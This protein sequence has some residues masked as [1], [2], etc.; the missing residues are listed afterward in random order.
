MKFLREHSCKWVSYTV[1][2]LSRN[3]PGHAKLDGV[4]TSEHRRDTCVKLWVVTALPLAVS[5]PA[6]S[7]RKHNKHFRGP[8]THCLFRVTF[9]AHLLVLC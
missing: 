2:F 6:I 4:A 1:F 7:P 5:T 8:A 3:N 9:E